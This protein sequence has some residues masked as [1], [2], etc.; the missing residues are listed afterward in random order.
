MHI[1]REKSTFNSGR[2]DEP[3]VVVDHWVSYPQTRQLLEITDL[4]KR[5]FDDETNSIAWLQD[6]NLATDGNAPLA[7]LD[8]EEGYN[9]VKNLL[10]RIEYGVLA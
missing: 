6:A 4:A 5:V 7:L 8:T 9:R 3:A 1:G 10:L 2:V